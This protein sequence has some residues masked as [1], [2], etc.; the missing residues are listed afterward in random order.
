LPGKNLKENDDLI[1]SYMEKFN[2]SGPVIFIL[3]GEN[4]EYLKAHKRSTRQT[5][6]ADSESTYTF[7]EFPKDDPCLLIYNEGATATLIKKDAAGKDE[8]QTFSFKPSS[9]VT[10]DSKCYTS[11]DTS[12]QT[13]NEVTKWAENVKLTFEN[14]DGNGE[15]LLTL[16]FPTAK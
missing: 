9:V 10:S 12:K 14:P 13:E 4:N 15:L 7:E 3:T 16:S 8:L 11:G 6:K 1:K 5:N 2:A